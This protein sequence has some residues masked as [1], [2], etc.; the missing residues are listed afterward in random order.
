MFL[1]LNP[2]KHILFCLRTTVSIFTI[3]ILN[4]YFESAH[5]LLFHFQCSVRQYIV[6]L[7]ITDF[8]KTAGRLFVSKNAILF[9]YEICEI[10]DFC[11]HT[12]HSKEGLVPLSELYKNGADDYQGS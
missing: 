6:L 3:D 11:L 12:S 7:Y 9:S 5:F 2:G 4:L 1:T 8:P 10:A